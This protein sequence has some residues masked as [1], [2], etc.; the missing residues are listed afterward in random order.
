MLNKLKLKKHY[1][2]LLQFVIGD[3][4]IRGWAG[5]LG[6]VNLEYYLKVIIVASRDFEYFQGLA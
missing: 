5:A 6:F 1:G 2:F 4:S 3:T